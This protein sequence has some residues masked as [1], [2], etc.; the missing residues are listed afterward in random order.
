M[1]NR[2]FQNWNLLLKFILIL[3][4]VFFLFSIL[5]IA[6]DYWPLSLDLSRDGINNFINIF[7]PSF[8]IG[9][10][11]LALFIIW[12]TFERMNQTEKR[13]RQTQEQLRISED[14]NKFNN[15]FKHREEFIEYFKTTSFYDYLININANF[16]ITHIYK[17]LYYENYNN[18]RP[19]LN[20]NS[21]NKIDYFLNK[22]KNSTI[23]RPHFNLSKSQ[24]PE[25]IEI[26]RNNFS[27]IKDLFIEVNE[28]EKEIVKEKSESENIFRTNTVCF[29]INE[30]YWAVKFFESI[31]MFD[32]ENILSLSNFENNYLKYKSSF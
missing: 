17:K 14:N 5:L 10:V 25:L 30:I 28:R 7:N 4:I 9:A 20:E 23:N 22:V 24:A 2:K 32:G 27:Y 11:L 26:I 13:I 31:K 29:Y 1:E 12:L 6:K 19:A 8:E 21:K 3:T 18:F 15:Y 16:Q